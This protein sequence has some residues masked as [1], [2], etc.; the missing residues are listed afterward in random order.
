MDPDYAGILAGEG[1]RDFGREF[2]GAFAE[3][4]PVFALAPA[5]NGVVGA[6]EEHADGEENVV[7]EVHEFLCALEPLRRSAET[8]IRVDSRR[9]RSKAAIIVAIRRE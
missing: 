5:A 7:E 3:A 2:T 4:V 8:R 1:S 6:E 9:S